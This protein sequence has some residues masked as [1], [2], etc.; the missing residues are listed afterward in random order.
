[1]KETLMTKMV[2]VVEETLKDF[3]ATMEDELKLTKGIL[4]RRWEG[5]THVVKKDKKSEYQVFFSIQRNKMIKENPNIKFGEISKQVSI[6][7]K[8]MSPEEKLHYANA[9]SQQQTIDNF[10]KEYGKMSIQELKDQ[11][12]EK[13]IVQ[14]K[15]RKKDDLIEFLVAWQEKKQKETTLT[16]QEMSKGRSKLELTAEDK[17]EEEEDF[18][19][20]E[21]DGSL[22]EVACDEDDIL[23]SDD[24]IFEEDE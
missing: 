3:F 6:M 24:D 14:G 10:R 13:G 20:Q 17:E 23:S 22:S 5:Q 8:N 7:W 21:D 16:H 4:W 15:S 1:M 12:K 2:E 9:S 18:Y 19:F 11:C